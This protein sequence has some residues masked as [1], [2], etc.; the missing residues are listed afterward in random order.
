MSNQK[1]LEIWKRNLS[2]SAL[3]IIR[4]S[5]KIVSKISTDEDLSPE[6][7]KA[8]QDYHEVILNILPLEAMYY[9]TSK[10]RTTTTLSLIFELNRI[11]RLSEL[12]FPKTDR[13]D[14]DEVTRVMKEKGLEGKLSR[15]EVSLRIEEL[16]GKRY[17]EPFTQIK[18]RM[19][20][21]FRTLA[22]LSKLAIYCGHSPSI[23]LGLNI[24]KEKLL[25]PLETIFLDKNLNILYR[26]DSLPLLR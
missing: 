26:L 25:E 9:D 8:C 20:K 10:I 17:S 6:G 18:D 3:I 12:E 21:G 14:K 1:I 5:L 2:E 4:H 19:I 7:V 16:G 22:S 13:R 24:E 11:Y 15:N 23:E